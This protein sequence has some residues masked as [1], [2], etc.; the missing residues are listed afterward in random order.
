MPMYEYHCDSCGQDFS[1]CLKI[2]E[3]SDPE[4][5]ECPHCAVQG[6]VG[7]KIGTPLVSYSTNP[8]MKT[9]DD[10][11][12]RLQEIASTKGK[13]HTINTRSGGV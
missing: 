4:G 1:M 12:A 11:N 10:F 7:M 9:S 5:K 3:R 6:F 13:G 8:G 2:S